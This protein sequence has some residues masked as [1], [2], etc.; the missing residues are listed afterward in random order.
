MNLI[1][2]SLVPFRER[3]EGRRIREW[4]RNRF[5]SKGSL[6]LIRTSNSSS[7]CDQ[8]SRNKC[9]QNQKCYEIPPHSSQLVRRLF[10][11]VFVSLSAYLRM[12]DPT[13]DKNH[14]PLPLY[15]K[16]PID[17]IKTTAKKTNSW[18]SSSDGYH[19]YLRKHAE[20]QPEQSN[21]PTTELVSPYEAL[22]TT[23]RRTKSE[24]FLNSWDYH[25]NDFFVSTTNNLKD[26]NNN[27]NN[28]DPRNNIH[29]DVSHIVDSVL[30]DQGL[31]PSSKQVI[32]IP[33]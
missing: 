29:Q 6:F 31:A 22:L 24:P 3:S 7:C 25:Y 17:R 21:Q 14:R 10:L 26:N 23:L 15:N 8:G 28:P 5:A 27:N 13:D 2:F 11:F 18:M 4:T 30:L 19:R 12:R 9:I 20:A 32:I 1:S 33:S 16:S